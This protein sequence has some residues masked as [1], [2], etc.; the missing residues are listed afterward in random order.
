MLVVNDEFRKLLWP[1]APEER[2]QLEASIVA[3]GCRDPLV[4]WRLS[5][6]LPDGEERVLFWDQPDTIDQNDIGEYRIWS[7]EED[8][9]FDSDW[10]RIL[11]DGHNRYEICTRL[12]IPFE[13]IDMEFANDE[14][15][16]DWIDRNQAG[17]RN[18]TPDQLRL[19]R[20]RIYNRMK[21]AVTNEGGKNQHS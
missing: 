11:I 7:S 21:K 9:F 14:A 20:G 16:A 19:I 18:A 5:S 4:V 15:A 8:D 2:E 3:E 1:L 6:W 10:P 17:R 13:V 12:D